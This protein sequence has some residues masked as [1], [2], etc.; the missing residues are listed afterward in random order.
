MRKI[1]VLLFIIIITFTGCSQSSE[2][3]SKLNGEI[4]SLNEKIIKVTDELNKKDEVISSLYGSISDLKKLNKELSDKNELTKSFEDKINFMKFKMNYYESNNK[5]DLT[6]KY[7]SPKNN[8]FLIADSLDKTLKD[9]KENINIDSFKIKTL[10]K[11]NKKELKVDLYEGYRIC[12]PIFINDNTVLF[13]TNNI[14]GKYEDDFFYKYDIKSDDLSLFYRDDNF[15]AY[16]KGYSKKLNNDNIVFASESKILIFE[17]DS[18]KLLKSI[19]YPDELKGEAVIIS[20][21]GDKI[22]YEDKDGMCVSS[23]E[24]ENPTLLIKDIGKELD[25]VGTRYYDW[26][27]DDKKILYNLLGYEIS[28]GIGIIDVET[29][30]NKFY[31]KVDYFGYCFLSDNKSILNVY[32]YDFNEI[33]IIDIDRNIEKSFILDKSISYIFNGSPKGLKIP[34]IYGNDF[35]ILDIENNEKITI[36]KTESDLFFESW[37]PSSKNILLSKDHGERLFLY[38]VE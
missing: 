31:E 4:K 37:S 29:L 21:N 7:A 6:Y 17:K 10:D 15:T 3:V 13:Y 19:I 35:C 12:D 14:E 36:N 32:G 25:S 1:A 38:T 28:F 5:K 34:V 27:L 11:S 24:F 23:L 33:S 26:S 20:N 8:N 30:N 16:G 18:L 22:A 9:K 2:E